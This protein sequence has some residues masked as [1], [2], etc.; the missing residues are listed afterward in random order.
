[1][2]SFLQRLLS[3]VFIAAAVTVSAQSTG[4]IS[5]KVIDKKTGEELIG[6]TIL[7][8][9]TSLGAVTDYEGKYMIAGVAPGTYN[10]V[11]SYVSYNKKM[12]KG[13]EVK[14]KETTNLSFPMEESSKELNEVV[15]QVEVKKESANALLIQQKNALSVSSGV[16]A[17]LIRKTPDRTTADVLKRVSGASVQDNRFAVVRGLSDRYN[18]GYLNG[19]PLPST[20]SDRKAFSLDIIPAS[21]IDNMQIVKGATPDLPGD[22]G[23]GIIQINT[24]DIPEENKVTINVAGQYHSLTTFK[25]GI[26][27]TTSGSDWLGYDGGTRQLPSGIRS[28]EVAQDAGNAWLTPKVSDTKQ[29]NNNFAPQAIGSMRP[30]YSLQLSASRRMKLFNNDLG[31]IFAWSY[32]NTVRATPFSTASPVV[33]PDD[34][35]LNPNTVD[36]IFYNYDSYK[37]TV[38]NGGVL[39]F[40]YKVGKNS[41][42]TFKNMLT[43]TGDDQTIHQTGYNYL[44]RN[45]AQQTG[46]TVDTKLY[47][48]YIYYYQSSRMYSSQLSGEHLLSQN[49][50]IKLKY[51][52]SYNNIHREV[53]DYRRIL[54]QSQKNESSGDT[55]FGPKLVGIMPNAR[56][57]SPQASGRY[58][59]ALDEQMYSVGY[60]LTVPFKLNFLTKSEVKLGGFHQWRNRKFQ[61]RN[62]MYTQDDNNYDDSKGSVIKQMGPGS[63][64]ANENIDSSTHYLSETTQGSDQY[65]ASSRLNAGYAMLDFKLAKR[66]RVIGGVRIEQFNQKVSS[67]NLGA[68]KKV[69]T[70]YVDVL[71]SLNLV[72]ELTDKM[73]LRA[74]A[75]KTVSRPEFREFA[76]LAFYEINYNAIITGNPDLVRTEIYNFDFKYEFFPTAGQLFSINPFFKRFINPVEAVANPGAGGINQFT[77]INAPR[78]QSYGVELEARVNLGSI[79]HTSENSMLRNFTVFANYA[80][81]A[82]NVSLNDTNTL[83]DAVDKR[84]MQGQSNYV[85]NAGVMYSDP[86]SNLDISITGNRIGSRIAFV[87]QSKRFVIWENPRTVIDLSVSKTFFKKLQT[88]ITLGDILAQP[89]VYYYD[90]NQ[91]HQYDDNSD[92][93][94]YKYKYGY[95]VQLSIGYTF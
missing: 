93:A 74:S 41:K 77:Y 14:A 18:M 10:L 39:N 72:Y 65:D 66:L 16:S 9:G 82:S 47:D 1:M 7:L 64:F 50:K 27:G 67:V 34:R 55:A 59:S 62:F 75:A 4:R 86:K 89:L 32:N 68:Q 61:A 23:G 8:E 49:S 51:T 46:S 78:A 92:V 84:P 88:K 53:P 5:G 13:V 17:D 40:A 57:Y 60:D 26:R 12:I 54:Y 81:I 19:A 20:E 87:N 63:A 44:G 3:I 95:T 38:I 58:F 76:Q 83:P 90:L 73:N 42:F 11:V 37:N 48:N 30:S 15:V 45:T 35:S 43:L 25:E 70:T 71:P 6:V 22:F 52:S 33:G 36:G 91:N 29:F 28:T 24:R 69:D 56:S 2:K 31:L 80:L 79:G 85:F 21:V 94:V